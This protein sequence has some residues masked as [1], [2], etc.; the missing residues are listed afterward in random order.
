MIPNVLG[1]KKTSL[2]FIVIV[3]WATNWNAMTFY[4][5]E[6][7]PNLH[8]SAWATTLHPRHRDSRGPFRKNQQDRNGSVG[9]LYPKPKNTYVEV[10]SFRLWRF[11]PFAL[12]RFVFSDSNHIL[13]PKEEQVKETGREWNMRTCWKQKNI[14]QTF[15]SNHTNTQIFNLHYCTTFLN[16][17]RSFSCHVGGV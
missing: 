16:H 9:W 10:H 8:V 2:T 4:F 11:T 14:E 6:F 3:T 5:S 17:V 1:R 12:F 15:L 13:R 7:L